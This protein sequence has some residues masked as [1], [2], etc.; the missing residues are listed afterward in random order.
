MLIVHKQI[1]GSSMMSNVTMPISPN[2]S[3][4]PQQVTHCPF[5]ILLSFNLNMIQMTAQLLS[6]V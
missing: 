4:I 5:V 2:W 3:L 6:T 1:T